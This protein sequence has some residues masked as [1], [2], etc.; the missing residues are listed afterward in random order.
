MTHDSPKRLTPAEWAEWARICRRDGRDDLVLICL[1]NAAV[2][3]AES[4]ATL[5]EMLEASEP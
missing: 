2:V 1:N 3:A 4:G 5:A